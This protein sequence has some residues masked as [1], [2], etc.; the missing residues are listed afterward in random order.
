MNHCS[1]VDCY[2]IGRKATTR[3]V[4]NNQDGKPPTITVLY[5][6]KCPGGSMHVGDE[7]GRIVCVSYFNKYA[8]V[9]PAGEGTE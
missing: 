8:M 1:R 4:V 9:R 2:Y 3:H 6:C 5:G 7:D